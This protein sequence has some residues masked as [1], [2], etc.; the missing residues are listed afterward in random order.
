MTP[1]LGP[2]RD[3]AQHAQPLRP[4]LEQRAHA[5]R[6]AQVEYLP[7]ALLEFVQTIHTERPGHALRATEKIDGHGHRESGDLL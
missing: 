4:A 5:L 6:Q 1:H 2:W 7:Q 3:R